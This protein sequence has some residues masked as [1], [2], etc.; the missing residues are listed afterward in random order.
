MVQLGLSVLRLMRRHGWR[1]SLVAGAVVVAGCALK[2][3]PT[4]SAVVKQALPQG[5]RIPGTWRAGDRAGEVGNGWVAQF[6]DPALRAIVDEAIAHNPDLRAAAARVAI[7]QQTVVV[8][9]SKLLPSIG[10]GLNARALDDQDRGSTGSTAVFLSA[11]WEADVWGRLRAQQAAAQAGY[12]ATALDYAWARQSLAATTAKLWYVAIESRQ[13]LALCEQAVDIYTRLSTLV[14]DRRR[15]GKVSDLDVVDMQA[16]LE[17]AQGDVQAA[18]QAY[19]ESRRALELLLGRYPAAEIEVAT[20]Y[21]TVQAMSPAGVP[22]ALLERRPDVL[23]AEQ[24]VVAAF[25]NQESAEL[26]LLPSF[27]LSLGGGAIQRHRAVPAAPESLARDRGGRR[28][29]A[30]V[31][32][33]GPCRP[34]W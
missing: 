15:A 18:R 20:T 23:A 21:P 5:T 13:L 26:A 30:G 31:R 27:G 11:G 28:V 16:R 19:G 8:V 9:G 2:E 14:Q 33:G 1:L 10:I 25:R 17:Q 22:A 24:A 32:G 4:H 3:P 29:G 34:R 12:Q 7:A 6:N